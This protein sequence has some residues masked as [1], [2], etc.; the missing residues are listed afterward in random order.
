MPEFPIV[1]RGQ[2]ITEALWNAAQAAVH[3]GRLRAGSGIRLHE[4]PDFTL[5]SAIGG[6]TGGGTGHAFKVSLT[7]H[8]ASIT[9]G[10]VNGIEPVIGGV[11]LSGD[12][13]GENIPELR[14]KKPALDAKRRGYIALEAIC[15]REWKIVQGDLTVVQVAYYDSLDGKAPPD[16]SGGIAAAGGIPGL[17]GRRVRY[18]IARLIQRKSGELEVFQIVKFDVTHRVQA[19]TADIARHFFSPA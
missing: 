11:L 16:G 7:E 10:T 9:P 5:I 3:A 2:P 4:M 14:W 12:E 8:G 18:P 19:R 15:D 17:P 1:A 13:A 6:G